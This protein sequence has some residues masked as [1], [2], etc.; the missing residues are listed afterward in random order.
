[1][2]SYGIIN[3]S[4]IYTSEDLQLEEFYNL[5]YT[6]IEGALNSYQIQLLSDELDKVYEIQEKEFG[7]E[8]LNSI[9]ELHLARFPLAYSE[10]FVKLASKKELI[11]YV[12][13]ILGNYFVLH[14]QNGIINMPNQEHHQSSWH[15]DLPYQNWTSN[16]PLACNVYYCL[17]DF[18]NKTGATFVLPYSHQFTNAPSQTYMEKHS[19]QI[20]APAG[21]AILFNSMLFHKAGFNFTNDKLRRGINHVYVTPIITQQINLPALLKGKYADDEFLNMLFGYKTKLA[22]SVSE[23]RAMR[24]LKTISK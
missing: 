5:G 1:M 12:E 2:K 10:E 7:I 16:K 22:G 15:R 6:V 13:K 11:N 8:K 3:N 20:I 9:N 17:D 24:S 4:N 19:L 18:N 23:Y 14:L 21:S